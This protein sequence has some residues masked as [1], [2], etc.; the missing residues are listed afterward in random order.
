MRP[1]YYYRYSNTSSFK[2][3]HHQNKNTE[4][5]NNKFSKQHTTDTNQTHHH[6]QS[7]QQSSNE[8]Q[9]HFVANEST[10]S[11]Q[12]SPGVWAN[13]KQLWKSSKDFY[14]LWKETKSVKENL[15]LHFAK[16]IDE[17]LRKE[18][19]EMHKSQ[20]EI[21]Q[22]EQ[23]IQQV[24]RNPS[25]L[26]EKDL[27]ALQELGNKTQGT[28]EAEGTENEQQIP[29]LKDEAQKLEEQL[30]MFQN[31]YDEGKMGQMDTEKVHKML[32]ENLDQEQETENFKNQEK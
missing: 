10:S 29:S 4:I 24:R 21:Q 2:N 7:P 16:Q 30:K 18:E 25:E 31:M 14:M 27:K 26:S 13:L 8:L 9:E 15:P 22:L 11:N 3:H 12:K 19:S 28:D 1:T 5:N 20:E 32:K 6:Y 17:Q 23:I